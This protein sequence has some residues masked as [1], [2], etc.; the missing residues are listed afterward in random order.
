MNTAGAGVPATFRMRMVG[1]AE[2]VS[3]TLAAA[4]A[5]IF[6][7]FEFADPASGGLMVAP[8]AMLIEPDPVAPVAL[9]G[10]VAADEPPAD[11]G[12]VV[13]GVRFAPVPLRS[14]PPREAIVCE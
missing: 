2:Q 1:F 9:D 10:V 3:A 4:L 11:L 8:P 6:P 14:G 5:G 7:N 12:V 13:V